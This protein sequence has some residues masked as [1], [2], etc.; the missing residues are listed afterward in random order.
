M[1]Q[2]TMIR[3]LQSLNVGNNTICQKCRIENPDINNAV[4]PWFS[5]S[6]NN[7]GNCIVF[8][9]KIARGDD[10]GE[11]VSDKLVDVEPCGTI[12]I[13][14]NSWPYWSYTRAIMETVYGSLD[15]A[16]H[17]SSLTNLIKCNN[18]TTPDTSTFSQANRCVNENQFIIQEL[19]VVSP[20]VVVFY[21]GT[22]YDQFIEN[23]KP[24]TATRHEDQ[25]DT[26]TRV[27]I[28]QKQLPWWSRK[29]YAADGSLLTCF[30]RVGHPE[31][32]RKDEYVMEIANWI[33]DSLN[34][35]D[36]NRVV[37]WN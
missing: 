26:E 8:V 14:N 28:G 27:P 32:M 6:E 25:T 5:C 37:H 10:M 30:L 13:K 29:Y 21:T 33:T 34:S 1:S 36:S 22:E 19:E 31:R 9:G 11:L 20:K 3:L 23:I 24:R 15:A 7:H 2:K 35:Y 16:M 4:G 18:S 12:E 17:Y